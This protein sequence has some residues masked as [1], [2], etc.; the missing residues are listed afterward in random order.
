MITLSGQP[1]NFLAGGEFPVPV[2]QGLGT[3]AIEYKPFGVGLVFTPTV[4]S[5]D[6]INILVSPE[7]SDLDFTTAVQF[8][9]LVVPGL[10]VAG[11]QQRLNLRTDRASPSPVCIRHNVRSIIQVSVIG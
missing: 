5:E 3:V 4:L 2:P 10:Q 9:G 1:A 11:R 6:K 8:Q 7:V